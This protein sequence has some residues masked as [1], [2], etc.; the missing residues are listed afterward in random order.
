MTG[1]IRVMMMIGA[2]GLIGCAGGPGGSLSDAGE[3]Y[4]AGDYGAAY[5]AAEPL[6]DARGRRGEEAAYLAGLSA[7]QLGR[8]GEAA[9]HLSRAAKS[10]DAQLAGNAGAA[11]GLLLSE[12]NR[13]ADAADALED[14]AELLTGESR[15]RAYYYL[16]VAQQKLGRTAA[17]GTSFT[18]ARDATSDPDL[19][20]RIDR[21]RRTIGWTVQTGAFGEIDN[22]RQAA[23]QLAARVRGTTPR[24]VTATDARGNTLH[25]VQIGSFT[26]HD[27][28]R[29]FANNLGP[30]AVVTPRTR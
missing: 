30:P 27:S 25:L 24:I 1:L 5:P 13:Y 9:R 23:Q 16:A 18:L 20:A 28:A 8:P 11:L 10:R 26:T 14:A 2:L 7:Q 4:R 22:A 12:Q 15:A 17:A 21:Q 6:A 19:R 3:A 29:R